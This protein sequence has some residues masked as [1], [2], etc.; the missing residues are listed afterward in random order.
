[1]DVYRGPVPGENIQ[2]RILHLLVCVAVVAYVFDFSDL[3]E[4]FRFLA[5]V[6]NFFVNYGGALFALC[7]CG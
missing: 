4:E 7:G 2:S 5:L 6:N 3:V 1:V